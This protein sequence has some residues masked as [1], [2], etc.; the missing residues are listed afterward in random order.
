[1][2]R[3]AE[4]KT[5]I[6]LDHNVTF[7]DLE[8]LLKKIKSPLSAS[9]A[10]G[11]LRGIVA[12]KH[13]VMPS[14]YIPIFIGRNK[15]GGFNCLEEANEFASAIFSLQ[16]RFAHELV[17]KKFTFFRKEEYDE[18]FDGFMQRVKDMQAETRGFI[19]GL[20]LG[21]SDPADL[22]K[23]GIL[24]FNKFSEMTAFIDM[25]IR[26]KKNL[27]RD[28]S[29]DDSIKIHKDMVQMMDIM[30]EM[31]IELSISFSRKRLRSDSN[32]G[33]SQ[34]PDNV[35]FPGKNRR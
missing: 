29:E 22:D 11:Y 6:N 35:F 13:I 3:K 26:S 12:A 27:Q 30:F 21:D 4:M 17:N 5:E 8:R 2:K 10:V 1:M 23:D 25:V 24:V 7:S 19:R 9:E 33:S 14:R 16:N 28:K 18:S 32:K 15:S 34:I 31:I 20:D